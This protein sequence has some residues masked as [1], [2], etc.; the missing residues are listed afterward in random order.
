MMQWIVTYS[1]IDYLGQVANG[2]YPEVGK[3]VV[4]VGCGAQGF[5]Q[6]LN[7]RDSGLDITYALRDEEIAEK[8]DEIC[9]KNNLDAWELLK[10]IVDIAPNDEGLLSFIGAGPFED[11]ISEDNYK[12][13]KT[14]IDKI[15]YEN[16]KWVVV[17]ISSWN[18][19]K[20]LKELLNKL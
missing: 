12:L 15:L 7:L 17:V 16:Q 1:G 18:N 10:T 14:E 6:G 8:V 4:I 13:I 11:W 9:S 3:K 20:E 2:V 19:P 5:H